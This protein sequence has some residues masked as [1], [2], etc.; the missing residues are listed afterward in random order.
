MGENYLDLNLYNLNQTYSNLYFHAYISS[1]FPCFRPNIF[2][3]YFT[4]SQPKKICK[5]EK[6]KIRVILLIFFLP[7]QIYSLESS[8]KLKTVSFMVRSTFTEHTFALT[9]SLSDVFKPCV[10]TFYFS[11]RTERSRCTADNL[12]Q[13]S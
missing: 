1:K 11:E 8:K 6:L 7:S 5:C 13:R 3:S 2:C 9:G 12:C 4:N 10:K